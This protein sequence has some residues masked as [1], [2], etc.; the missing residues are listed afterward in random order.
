M[1]LVCVDI[2]ED[3]NVQNT[4]FAHNYNRRVC[5][6][7]LILGCVHVAAVFLRLMVMLRSPTNDSSEPGVPFG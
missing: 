1:N 6:V 5:L 3:A 7:T 2:G 4:N